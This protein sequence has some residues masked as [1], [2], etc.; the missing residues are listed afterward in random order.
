MLGP[1]KIGAAYATETG[2]LSTEFL[3]PWAWVSS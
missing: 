1:L 3:G 2:R